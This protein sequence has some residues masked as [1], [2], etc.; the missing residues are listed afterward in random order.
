MI[1][2][3]KRNI[4]KVYIIL[5][6]V[7]LLINFN[8]LSVSLLVNTNVL[9]LIYFILIFLKNI[10][11]NYILNIGT[12]LL[13]GYFIFNILIYFINIFTTN[14]VFILS[15]LLSNG[16]ASLILYVY[17]IYKLVVKSKNKIFDN[18][19]ATLFITLCLL[20]LVFFIV[21][22][23]KIFNCINLVFAIVMDIILLFYFR[24]YK[25]EK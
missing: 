10:N 25:N 18:I 11:I 12:I 14:N 7:Y 2:K 21:E 9:F 1:K 20:S 19:V 17:I 3:I 15:N 22:G 23:N 6:I 13:L 5:V 16:I 4:D 8:N 24:T